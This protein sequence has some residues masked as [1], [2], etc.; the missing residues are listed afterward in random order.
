[1]GVHCLSRGGLRRERRGRV[2]SAPRQE[3]VA[4]A[5]TS[6]LRSASVTFAEDVEMIV[7]DFLD[8]IDYYHKRK[9]SIHKERG[10]S[11]NI[12]DSLRN[13]LINQRKY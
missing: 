4:M 8:H 6:R 3:R 9:I 11:F 10:F 12:Y 7:E 1:M 2:L 13:L 5:R